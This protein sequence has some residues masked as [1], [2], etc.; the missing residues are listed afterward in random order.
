MF[1]NN[2]SPLPLE[3]QGLGEKVFLKDFTVLGFDFGLRH[4]GVAVGQTVTGTAHALASLK[5]R[6]GTPVW[7]EIAALISQWQPRALIVGVPIGLDGSEQSIT[8]AARK[9][10]EQL[11]EH[12]QLPVHLVDERF[13]TLEAKQHLFERGGSR[14]LSKD[15]IDGWSAKIITENGLKQWAD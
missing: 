2:F 15:N 13:T 9:F 8:Q 11:H 10:A 6:N 7:E 12:T 14:A 3:G 4:I 5:A 1:F